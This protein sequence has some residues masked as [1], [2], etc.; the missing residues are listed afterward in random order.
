MICHDR[1]DLSEE[2]DV[3][4]SKDSEECIQSVTIGILIMSLNFK[5]QFTF[6]DI[7]N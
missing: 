1:I 6:V 2:I 7:R 5:D 3:N 4:K